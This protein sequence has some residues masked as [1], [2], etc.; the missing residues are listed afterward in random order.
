MRLAGV[1]GSLTD[2]ELEVGCIPLLKQAVEIVDIRDVIATGLAEP[3]VPGIL[4]LYL[5]ALMWLALRWAA[6]L[7]RRRSSG[8][9]RG[10]PLGGGV[11]R[12]LC[13]AALLALGLLLTIARTAGR[14]TFHSGARF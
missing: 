5:L 1:A 3:A 2:V 8:P 11:L 4:L 7:R 14:S 13:A 9:S 10:I 6:R 12:L